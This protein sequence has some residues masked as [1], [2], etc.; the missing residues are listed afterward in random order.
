M[1]IVN[2]WLHWTM[3]LSQ[4]FNHHDSEELTAM[5]TDIRH[6]V[7]GDFD[8][9]QLLQKLHSKQKPFLANHWQFSSPAA[10]IEVALLIAVVSFAAWKKCC[11]QTSTTANIPMAA[12]IVLTPVTQPQPP[13]MPQPTPVPSALVYAQPQLPTFNFQK[14][15]A[16]V[17][18]YT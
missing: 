18:I 17:L 16:L 8:A 3:T 2:F 7:N 10:L 15:M 5:I 6:H 1:E 12:H 13:A 4:L 9:S 11:A 14:Q